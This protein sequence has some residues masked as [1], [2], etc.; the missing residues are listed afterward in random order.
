[1]KILNSK[2]VLPKVTPTKFFFSKKKKLKTQQNESFLKRKYVCTKFLT[3]PKEKIPDQI[4]KCEKLSLGKKV[5]SQLL[6]LLSTTRS[7]MFFDRIFFWSSILGVKVRKMKM[8][9]KIYGTWHS[10][11][12]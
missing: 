5:I 3:F 7:L 1:M 10:G 4:T 9:L 11:A 12:V 2:S 6:Q 8:D